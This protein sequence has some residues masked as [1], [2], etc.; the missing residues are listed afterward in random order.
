MTA[1]VNNTRADWLFS[2]T[3][4]EASF[5]APPSCLSLTHSTFTIHRQSLHYAAVTLACCLLWSVLRFGLTSLVAGVAFIH[6]PTSS[7]SSSSSMSSG[8][9]GYAAPT[10]QQ[11]T[12]LF[13]SER[14]NKLVLTTASS[15]ERLAA[16]AYNNSLLVTG[17]LQVATVLLFLIVD[18]HTL[19]TGYAMNVPMSLLLCVLELVQLVFIVFAHSGM[20]KEL[21]A[22]YVRPTKIWN[23]YVST[24]ICY[25]ALYFT[26]FCYDRA[27]FNV[28]GY[29]PNDTPDSAGGLPDSDTQNYN[30]IPTLFIFFLYFS[31][32]IMTSTGFGDIAPAKWY[33][34]L[35]NAPNMHRSALTTV[36]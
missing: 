21:L 10:E 1:V 31:G 34:I 17:S 3:T 4:I 20:M 5:T 32:A 36:H 33:T 19:Q 26:C 23:I 6:C 14:W 28:D 27:S 13:D 22:L 11:P 24:L 2:T 25:T 18:P 35:T 30:D 15:R 16:F 8:A 9:R 12:L 29:A 7:S